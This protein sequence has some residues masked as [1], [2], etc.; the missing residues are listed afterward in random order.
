MK[1]ILWVKFLIIA[2]LFFFFSIFQN[3]FL[4]YFNIMGT[5]LNLVFI[6]FFI[7]IFFEDKYEYVQ[8]FFLAIIAGFF[9]DTFLPFYF[10]IAIGSLLLIY[11]LKKLITHFLKESQDKYPIFY[12]IPLFS[13]CFIAYST[14]LYVSSI[15]LHLQFIFW[16]NI[17]MGLIYNLVFACAGFY[18]YK[19]VSNVF[20]KDRQLKLLWT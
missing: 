12:F 15:L 6:L 4:P 1:Q 7:L 5:S 11:F 17:L 10:G 14:L 16:A 18:I 2:L 13:T 20:S 9:L 19:K 8:G 3:S